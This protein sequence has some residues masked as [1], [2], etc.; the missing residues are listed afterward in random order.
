MDP[1]T[2]ELATLRQEV[3][4]LRKEMNLL[5]RFLH[6][7][8]DEHTG[9]PRNL[10]VTCGVIHV[11]NPHAPGTTQML[12]SGSENGPAIGLWDNKQKG[13]LILQ[14]DETGPRLTLLTPELKDAVLLYADQADGRG[15]AAVLD[16]G[17][18]RA[19][20]KACDDGCGAVSVVHDDGITR[21]CLRGDEDS[22]MLMAASLD[23]KA[24]V[25]ISSETELGGGQIVI[26]SPNGKPAIILGHDHTH[27]G[28]ILTRDNEGA[29]TASLPDAGYDKK[30][31]EE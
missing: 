2:T 11:D 30:R 27:G 26:S 13:R 24:T 10:I 4:T 1:S 29:P 28:I 23:L 8:T 3:A 21:I 19:L 5:R 31:E 17:N 6:V 14:V 20:L 12:I 16:N 22:G 18:P 15:L 7:E 9:E 25:K